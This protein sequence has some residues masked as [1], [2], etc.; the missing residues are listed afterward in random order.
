[1][2]YKIASW[3]TFIGFADGVASLG[4][5]DVIIPEENRLTGLYVDKQ[6]FAAIGLKTIFDVNEEFGVNLGIGL[7]FSGRN[8]PKTAASSI[9]IYYKFL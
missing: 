9:G 7:A 3:F 8:V 5:G 2:G 1:M 6:S 4:N